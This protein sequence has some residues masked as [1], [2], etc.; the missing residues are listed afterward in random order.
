MPGGGITVSIG[1]AT[2][3]EDG[4]SSDTLLHHADQRLY[5]NKKKRG[6]PPS[7]TLSDEQ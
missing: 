1:V 2:Y 4:T 6:C 7:N 5:D 3:P